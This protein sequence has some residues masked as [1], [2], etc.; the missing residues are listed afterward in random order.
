M[1]P[2]ANRPTMGA[3]PHRRRDLESPCVRI[4]NRR[5]DQRGHA[6]HRRGPCRLS[7]LSRRKGDKHLSDGVTPSSRQV[8]AD[9]SEPASWDVV[10]GHFTSELTGFKGERAIFIHNANYAGTAAFAGEADPF[11][12]RRQ[13]LANSAA[14]LVLGET[15]AIPSLPAG[16]RVGPSH[17]FIGRGKVRHARPIRLRSRQGRHGTVGPSGSHGTKGPRDRPVGCGHTTGLRRDGGGAG[18]ARRGYRRER[19]SWRSGGG[20]RRPAGG[21]RGYSRRGRSRYMG[22]PPA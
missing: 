13:V 10:S 1:G 12:Y 11:E 5:V 4:P 9:L 2:G 16:L 6:G 8:L 21:S 3:H 18:H 15:R 20:Q 14:S 17:D 19:L 7:S 22:P